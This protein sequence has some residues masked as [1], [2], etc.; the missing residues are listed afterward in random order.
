MSPPPSLS[1]SHTQTRASLQQY[2]AHAAGSETSCLTMAHDNHTLVS[3]GGELKIAITSSHTQCLLFT[4]SEGDD[5]L[6]VWD[7]RSF[8]RPVH[9]ATGLQ[10]L[11][12]V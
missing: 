2:S 3:R 11:F 12:S 9:V 8:K 1:L 5:T 4:F 6:K 10:N 7:I